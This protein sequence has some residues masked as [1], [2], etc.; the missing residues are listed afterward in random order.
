MIHSLRKISVSPFTSRKIEY[1]IFG[2]VKETPRHHYCTLCN[3]LVKE[4]NS[5][6]DKPWS[7]F[8][9]APAD[10]PGILSLTKYG[11]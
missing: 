5:S 2:H 6:L 8:N 7:N 11:I 10:I 4:N 3:T 1:S 9:L